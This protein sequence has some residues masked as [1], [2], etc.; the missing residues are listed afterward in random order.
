MAEVPGDPLTHAA[1]RHR[2][3]LRIARGGSGVLG[4][5][6]A[7]LLVEIALRV[8][9]FSLPPRLQLVLQSLHKTPFSDERLVPDPI[10]Q[11]DID[12]LTIAR[13]VT[14]YEQI[15]SAR[16]RFTVTTE[17]LWG[18][19][20]AFRTTQA[21]VD[22]HV[23]AIALGDSF[24]FCFTDER[25]CW[26]NRLGDITGRNIVNL[27][28]VSTGSVSHLRVLQTFGMPLQPP[29]VLWQWFGND[30]N[31]DYG[32]ADLRGET[33]VRSTSAPPPAT[34]TTWWDEHSAVVV[35]LKLL[36]GS[37]EQFAGSLQFLDRETVTR[38]DITLEFG[39]PYL[40]GAFDMSQPQ[41]Q[42]GWRRS[43]DALREARALVESYGGRLVVLLMP[44]KE[45]VYRDMAAPVIGEDR[46]ALLDASYALMQTFCQHEALSYIDL[47]AAF[48]PY[49]HQGEQ[50]YYTTDLHLNPRGNTVLASILADWLAAH[51]SIFEPHGQD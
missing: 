2:W 10:W 44:T 39:R 42:D 36:L 5:L 15:G 45:Q 4:I 38:G 31:E 8:A 50:L 21:Q 17:T 35:L 16:V 19:R 29:L 14:N 25:D 37:D 28:I 27:G 33:G 9:F 41:N 18:S 47:L 13:P 1:L 12:Y 30:A 40:W 49:A 24:T 43:Q 48:K 6:F 26:V 22:R 32:L 34:K 7:W 3:A 11:S 23:D 20:A 46:M 51:P